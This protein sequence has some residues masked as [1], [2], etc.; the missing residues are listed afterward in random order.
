MTLTELKREAIT[1]QMALYVALYIQ[2]ASKYQSIVYEDKDNCCF[3]APGRYMKYDDGHFS[4]DIQ[5]LVDTGALT[6]LPGGDGDD[7]TLKLRNID[8]LIS[9]ITTHYDQGRI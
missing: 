5:E 9:T 3:F 4:V 2:E 8:Q 7:D 6:V 1:L